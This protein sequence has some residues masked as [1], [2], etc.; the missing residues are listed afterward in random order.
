MN[1]RDDY[2]NLKDTLSWVINDIIERQHD[3]EKECSNNS[4]DFNEGRR[5]A[6]FEVIDMLK[7]RF[8]IMDIDTQLKDYTQKY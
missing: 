2:D 7:S 4:T 6:Y 8:E 5:L 1:A 3:I